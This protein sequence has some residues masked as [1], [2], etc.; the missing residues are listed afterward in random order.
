MAKH[1]SGHSVLTLSQIDEVSVKMKIQVK[2]QDKT[3]EVIIDDIHSRPIHASVEGEAF[4]VWPEE[5]IL[6]TPSQTPATEAATAV[7]QVKRGTPLSSA[8]STSKEISAPIPG[9]IIDILVKPGEF[10]K[11]GQELCTL[12][13]MKMKNF[14]RANREGTI[15][16]ILVK[17]GEQVKHGQALMRFKD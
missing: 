12:E 1:A 5:A 16:E 13:A 8:I 6:P 17:A 10:V 7:E 4:E 9:V 14:I 15:A 3:Y 2:I 11:Y